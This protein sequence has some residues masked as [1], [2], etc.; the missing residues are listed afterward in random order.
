M[1][2]ITTENHLPVLHLVDAAGAFLPS[3]SDLFADRYMAGRLFRNQCV[4]SAKGVRQVALVLGHS[5][6]GGAYVP[7]LCD[8]S[9]WKRAVPT[10]PP[11]RCGTTA[12]SIPPTPAKY[13]VSPCRR[14]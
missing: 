9:V 4:L 3:Q 13:W 8:Y 6:A 10:T 5:T 11:R 2:D 7:T 12:S 1:T 14:P